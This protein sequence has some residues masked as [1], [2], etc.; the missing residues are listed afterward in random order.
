MGLGKRKITSD[1]DGFIME[2]KT[3]E[4]SK[5]PPLIIKSHY[6]LPKQTVLTV[7][8]PTPTVKIDHERTSWW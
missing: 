6:K 7:K 8:K 2:Y 1:L 3:A 5:M 4:P